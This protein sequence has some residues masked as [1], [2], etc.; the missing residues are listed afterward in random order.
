M[1]REESEE[2]VEDYEW[3]FADDDEPASPDPVAYAEAVPA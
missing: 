1:T 2:Q 3:C